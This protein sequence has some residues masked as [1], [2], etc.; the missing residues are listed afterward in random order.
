MREANVITLLNINLK[1]LQ[2]FILWNLQVYNDQRSNLYKI[3][4]YKIH[5]HEHNFH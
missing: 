3:L 2:P 1:K 5:T 4:C